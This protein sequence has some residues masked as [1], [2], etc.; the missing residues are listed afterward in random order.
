[1]GPRS[2]TATYLITFS[3]YGCHLHGDELGS[4]DPAH[5]VPG[6]RVIEADA[7]RAACE[8]ERMDQAPY[9]MDQVRRGIVLEAIRE[10]SGHRGW[11]LLAAH[12]RSTHVHSVV[13]ATV[14][15]ERVMSD[16]KSYASRR[17][18]RTGLDEQDRS[19]GHATVVRDG[20]GSLSVFR[21]LFGMSWQSRGKRWR[22]SSA[23]SFD[24]CTGNAP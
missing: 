11:K 16:F 21:R 13:E 20:F 9:Q 19:G 23:R 6:S 15:P 4:V 24:G 12:V 22:C 18:N 10:A 3:C 7:E 8:K 2:K 14:R 1:M 17:L 5:N